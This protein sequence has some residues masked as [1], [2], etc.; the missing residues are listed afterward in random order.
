MLRLLDSCQNKVSTDQYH[1]TISQAQV[2]SSLRSHVLFNWPL[3]QYCFFIGS[4][5]QVRLLHWGEKVE[6]RKKANF[7]AN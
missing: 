3:I 4:Q 6:I 7:G 5:A 1:V 2:M